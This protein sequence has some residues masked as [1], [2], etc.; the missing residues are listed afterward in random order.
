MR[1]VKL[2][3]LAGQ[4]NYLLDR[5]YYNIPVAEM[6]KKI[7]DGSVFD[8]LKKKSMDDY[9]DLSLIDSNDRKELLEH[10]SSMADVIDEDRKMG[11]MNNGVCLL[12]AYVIE[13]IQ[14]KSYN[15]AKA[16]E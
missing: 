3:I 10:F 7:R 14:S 2:T 5:G 1:L 15:D 16:N 11:V 6:K 12:L 8:F 13:L 9:L 4:L